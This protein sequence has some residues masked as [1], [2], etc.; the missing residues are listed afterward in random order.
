MDRYL[1]ITEA[2]AVYDNYSEGWRNIFS[3]VII[4]Y[5]QNREKVLIFVVNIFNI[6]GIAKLEIKLCN[7]NLNLIYRKFQFCC[8]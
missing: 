3:F 5:H 1:I 4:R 6:L 7:F 8:C 2:F